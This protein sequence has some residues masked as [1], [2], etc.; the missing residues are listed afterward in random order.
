MPEA[1]AGG[2]EIIAD[3]ALAVVEAATI[4]RATKIAVIPAHPPRYSARNC[5]LS[6]ANKIHRIHN[7]YQ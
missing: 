5:Q 2:F 1:R 7:L 6:S 3:G 4:F